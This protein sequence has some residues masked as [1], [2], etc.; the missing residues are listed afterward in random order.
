MIKLLL[1]R[2]AVVRS[3]RLAA[4]DLLVPL[5]SPAMDASDHKI[6]DQVPRQA[7]HTAV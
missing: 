6:E 1:E 4:A 5:T 3:L 7:L 2:A